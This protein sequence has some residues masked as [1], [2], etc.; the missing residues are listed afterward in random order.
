MVSAYFLSSQWDIFAIWWAN[1]TNS[2]C[3][4]NDRPSLHNSRWLIFQNSNKWKVVKFQSN[5]PTKWSQLMNQCDVKAAIRSY[6]FNFILIEFSTRQ[7][8]SINCKRVACGIHCKHTKSIYRT[9]T[10]NIFAQL[11]NWTPTTGLYTL[12]ESKNQL[13]SLYA[14]LLKHYSNGHIFV[15]VVSNL[16]FDCNMKSYWIAY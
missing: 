12:V 16:H 5:R 2:N 7:K 10:A 13:Q 15:V 11:I 14:K 1:R 6:S 4:T 3:S 9:E 8:E